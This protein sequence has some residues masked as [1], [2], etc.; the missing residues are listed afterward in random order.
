MSKGLQIWHPFTQEAFDPAPLRITKA[1]GV[2]LYTDDG[3]RLIDILRLDSPSRTAF[4]G[5]QLKLVFYLSSKPASD[6]EAAR[7][8]GNLLGFPDDLPDLAELRPLGGND[9]PEGVAESYAARRAWGYLP[10]MCA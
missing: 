6:R 1:E 3:R 2:Y 10:V 5:K 4:R 8:L 9:R 7:L